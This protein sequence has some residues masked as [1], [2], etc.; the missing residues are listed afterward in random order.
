MFNKIVKHIKKQEMMRYGGK[1]HAYTSLSSLSSRQM[2]KYIQANNSNNLCKR[3]HHL[4]TRCNNNNNNNQISNIH[5]PKPFNVLS[6]ISPFQLKKQPVFKQ[7]YVT[8]TPA[9]NDGLESI[10]KEDNEETL[11]IWKDDTDD[12]VV[13]K[14]LDVITN[15]K[16][17]SQRKKT[18]FIVPEIKRIKYAKMKNSLCEN[19]LYN[20]QCF[21]ESCRN[22]HDIANYFKMHE[23]TF[24]YVALD[25]SMAFF[26]SV[27][28]FKT[29]IN[30]L[31]SNG[32]IGKDL[33][34]LI[35][36]DKK[37]SELGFRMVKN[38]DAKFDI[39]SNYAIKSLE[40]QK[41]NIRPSDYTA[42]VYGTD[43]QMLDKLCN[44]LVVLEDLFD[45][46][47]PKEK[48]M[49]MENSYI[50]LPKAV[51]TDSLG[52]HT[53]YTRN[54][55]KQLVVK[56]NEKNTYSNGDNIK[57]FQDVGDK[58]KHDYTK[59]FMKPLDDSNDETQ[60]SAFVSFML[61]LV[62]HQVKPSRNSQWKDGPFVK[63]SL[64][65]ID[66][67]NNDIGNA[68]ILFS[69]FQDANGMEE[70]VFLLHGNNSGD[71]N[72]LHK[73]LYGAYKQFLEIPHFF[74]E[75]EMHYDTIFDIITKSGIYNGQQ[76]HS[77]R[78]CPHVAKFGKCII[79]RNASKASGMHCPYNHNP[80]NLQNEPNVKLVT[81]R[82]MRKEIMT[83]MKTKF[84][85]G[86]AAISKEFN[87]NVIIAD[88]FL[89]EKGNAIVYSLHSKDTTILNQ[90]QDK[91]YEL[92]KANEERLP[93]CN[94][95]L[96]NGV[97]NQKNCDYSH[98]LDDIEGN[99]HIIPIE[100]GTNHAM[101][102]S[103][104][105]QLIVSRL[106][107][108]FKDQKVDIVY[109]NNVEDST[110]DMKNL[111]VVGNRKKKKNYNAREQERIAERQN[112]R[113][114]DELRSV[115][116]FHGED[117]SED[118]MNKIKK[119]MNNLTKKFKTKL[120]P[121][122]DFICSPAILDQIP[123][124]ER[125]T[126]DYVFG[127]SKV[128]DNKLA[129]STLMIYA[130]DQ[131]GIQKG[132]DKLREYTDATSIPL[133][134][135]DLGYLFLKGNWD[136]LQDLVNKFKKEYNFNDEKDFISLRFDK[137]NEKAR[138]VAND[139]MH[140]KR[141]KQFVQT[142]YIDKLVRRD[143]YFPK[144][145]L[146]HNNNVAGQKSK[147]AKFLFDTY[148]DSKEYKHVFL[149][150]V[151][152]F[153]RGVY[154][155]K[156]IGT[157]SDLNKVEDESLKL[158]SERDHSIING[159]NIE[160]KFI[161]WDAMG[162]VIGPQGKNIKG[163]R[164]DSGG[165][166]IDMPKELIAKIEPGKQPVYFHSAYEPE[167]NRKNN[168]YNHPKKAGGKKARVL[169]AQ[170]KRYDKF[171][172]EA[173]GNLY[174]PLYITGPAD[175]VDMAKM[176]IDAMVTETTE[177]K[178]NK[179]A[180]LS[181]KKS[182]PRTSARDTY[183]ASLR[184]RAGEQILMSNDDVSLIVLASSMQL[185]HEM[186]AQTLREMGEH[187]YEGDTMV[188]RDIAEL[189]ILECGMVPIFPEESHLD[190]VRSER[191]VDDK[192][193]L[194]P[195][196][197]TIMGH[198]DHG[199]TTLLD[200]LRK[201]AIGS[202]ET[203][204]ITQKIGG[205]TLKSQ[206][207]MKLT[208]IDTPGHA[209]FSSMR[210]TGANSSDI[211]VV[212]IAAEDGVKPQTVEALE[213]A[214]KSQEENNVP[215][216][217]AVTKIDKE[218]I[219]VERAMTDIEGQLLEN[220]IVTE[221]MGGEVQLVALSAISGKGL[222]EFV[223][224]ISLHADLLELKSNP[225]EPGEGIVLE[226]SFERGSG[227]VADLLVQWGT[228]KKNNYVVIGEEWG[229]VKR[230]K[231][232]HG[233]VLKSAGAGIPVQVTGFRGAPASG[234]E[235]FVVD[236]ERQCIGITEYRAELRRRGGV[237]Q[238]RLRVQDEEYNEAMNKDKLKRLVQLED[239]KKGGDREDEE[240][241]NENDKFAIML[242]A[243]STGT[244]IALEKCFSE[245]VAKY[246][247]DVDVY[248]LNTGTGDISATDIYAASD[249]GAIIYGFNS[250][251]TKEAK[252]LAQQN[253]VEIINH[254]IIYRLEDDLNDK[255]TSMMPQIESESFSGRAEVLDTFEING[256]NRGTKY[257]IN[258]M[259]VTSG[260][261]KNKQV[262]RVFRDDEL[263]YDH[264][265][266]K[267]MRIFKDDAT[268]VGSGGECGIQLVPIEINTAST[269]N[270]GG[271]EDGKKDDDSISSSNDMEMEGLYG[272]KLQPGDIVESY[273]IDMVSKK[274]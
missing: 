114:T 103:E 107:H 157:E 207:G 38:E 12:N 56:L 216:V 139:E 29:Q 221:N 236:N 64:S 187:G 244:L 191:M 112:W 135:N 146:K 130:F 129:K 136:Q 227:I 230:L 33:L 79:K 115:L 77:K 147:D 213:I 257:Q 137:K 32:V 237:A 256:K 219:D 151:E 239:R 124:S 170:Q 266:V 199:K 160:V 214:R 24:Q 35:S 166:M 165:A 179:Q 177:H 59:I 19:V 76:N 41:I 156:L 171:V 188:T 175:T 85:E 225:K 131:D 247:D 10:I 140:A 7:T 95:I 251:L 97:C 65:Y 193:P 265:E 74:Q 45:K 174:K 268:Q 30:Q 6:T 73:R 159:N 242:K 152:A 105:R 16:M 155:V 217:V 226:S 241:D 240:D 102:L 167:M 89:P 267:T 261:I 249:S 164:A 194:R 90:A 18:Q 93:F 182:R 229:R 142:E 180:R 163:V 264:L 255:L 144:Q 120:L 70:T 128:R 250:K 273:T 104:Y 22:E 47:Y 53:P 161:P 173:K 192:T 252:S 75:N 259:K 44:N 110:N 121:Q 42:V 153:H 83:T 58:R 126:I 196:V 228:L 13:E 202:G 218:D 9:Y 168:N 23:H 195:A 122:H 2:L 224:T 149:D 116:V 61:R 109:I 243:D 220:G 82:P 133:R 245:T 1:L 209:A 40:K 206:S 67:I 3:R 208:F 162:F 154:I 119:I 178:A 118:N 233:K 263:I 43:S 25:T 186:L 176:M 68:S 201:S 26:C 92:V 238:Q 269:A 91:M 172:L 50:H 150:E 232:D 72:K 211:N 66:I 117:V 204:G 223:E 52:V 262:Y 169:A 94:S 143:L 148:R 55:Q 108:A 132:I 200:T 54:R 101:Q 183:Y 98:Y 5:H 111:L 80:M 39:F 190:R 185:N 138:I 106:Q 27:K 69:E 51:L 215:L 8:T 181:G 63:R 87:N 71:V 62:P 234:E 96:K 20:N 271:D 21:D 34:W 212:V 141:M 99:H 210:Q 17:Q 36:D 49:T 84:D 81:V 28:H 235:F 231:D 4:F 127:K 253:G 203:G 254:K 88:H 145:L 134:N 222:D 189:L 198:V 78:F 31:F 248:V 258:G 100:Y 15:E 46:Q 197:I 272:I 14:T 113:V 123:S 158:W 48:K 274:L 246:N 184:R 11:T 260:T 57:I 37:L 60:W 270:E 86:A 125:A 205:F